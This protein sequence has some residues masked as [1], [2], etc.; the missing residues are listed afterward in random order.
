M[1]W[2][3]GYSY[4][5]C[6]MSRCCCFLFLIYLN[7]GSKKFKGNKYIIS[8]SVHS[9]VDSSILFGKFNRG[10]NKN[11]VFM[12]FFV[13][14]WGLFFI[15]FISPRALLARTQ[16]AITNRSLHLGLSQACCGACAKVRSHA[17][18]SWAMTSS[19][20]M[21]GRPLGVSNWPARDW[22]PRGK[23]LDRIRTQGGSRFAGSCWFCALRA[24]FVTFF[25][26]VMPSILLRALE[27]KPLN[28]VAS[29]DSGSQVSETYKRP[30]MS[31]IEDLQL[32]L[33]IC[34]LYMSST[35]TA[36]LGSENATTVDL[37]FEVICVRHCWAKMFLGI[38][39]EL[40]KI[41]PIVGQVNKFSLGPVSSSGWD[42]WFSRW[43]HWGLPKKNYW[44][45]NLDGHWMWLTLL[46]A[47]A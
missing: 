25:L 11:A 4:F 16:P 43:M 37:S 44:W 21:L 26:R 2:S 46:P 14:S 42:F 33:W 38:K 45:I 40:H 17:Q 32:R 9:A 15:H 19:H 30:D 23:G 31:G 12:P 13:F 3:W 28:L 7:F 10:A 27:S 1:G 5:F 47:S 39:I 29:V 18:K 22:G 6:W 34:A 41:V 36:W 24:N 35:V 20:W 8:T